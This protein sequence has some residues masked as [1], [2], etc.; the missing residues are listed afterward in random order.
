MEIKT[1]PTKSGIV[2]AEGKGWHVSRLLL[3]SLGV[4][5]RVL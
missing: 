4:W 1:R 3:L 5:E 2:V